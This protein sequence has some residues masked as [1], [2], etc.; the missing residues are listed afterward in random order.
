LSA[1]CIVYALRN[2][3]IVSVFASP[4]TKP[5]VC[6]GATESELPN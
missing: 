1:Y 5:D 3:P 2:V 4:R 6:L